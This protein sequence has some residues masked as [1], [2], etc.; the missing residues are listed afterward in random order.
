MNSLK[1]ESRL[2]AGFTLIELIIVVTII[3]ILAS[4]AIP[5]YIKYQ[6]KSKISSFALPIASACSKDII[7]YCI[8]LNPSTATS[9]DPS[10]TNLRNCQATNV[11]G[12]NLNVNINGSVLCSE[13]GVVSD[14][15]VSA[16]ITSINDYKAVCYLNNNGIE[17]TIEK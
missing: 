13:G 8:E 5:M 7:A 2:N 15:T 16:I 10:N 14:G 17:C 1:T 11:F 12:H 4:M 6:N 3:S 9:I